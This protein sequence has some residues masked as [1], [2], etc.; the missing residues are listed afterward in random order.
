MCP[1]AGPPNGS[2]SIPHDSRRSLGRSYLPSGSDGPASSV[3]PVCPDRIAE[4]SRR[5]LRRCATG[6]LIDSGRLM[7][8]LAEIERLI[9]RL[10]ERTS[11]RLLGTRLQPLTIERRIERAMEM[12]RRNAGSR[13]VVPDQFEVRL[14]PAD[15]ATLQAIHS[16]RGGLAASLE[17]AVLDFAKRHRYVVATKPRIELVGDPGVALGDV[18]VVTRDV[19]GGRR[20]AMAS[21]V[22]SSDEA[23]PPISDRTA[24]FAVPRRDPLFATLRLIRPDGV[25]RLVPFTGGPMTVGR[26]EDNDLVLLDPGVSRHHARFQMRRGAIVLVD[27]DSRNGTFVNDVAVREAVLGPGDRVRFGEMTVVVERAIATGNEAS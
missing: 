26:A 20:T 16:P 7:R 4:S 23:R 9:E 19:D 25:N 18:A 11:V 6:P 22:V 2:E 5:E 3:H 13:T 8:P 21:P 17:G 1:S 15:L 14:H 12:E 10:V 27:L 24:V